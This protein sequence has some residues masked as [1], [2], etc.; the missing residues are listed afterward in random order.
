MVEV[1]GTPFQTDNLTAAQ[2]VKS[3]QKNYQFNLMPLDD[4]KQIQDFRIQVV[5][6]LEGFRLGN[7]NP[8]SRIAWNQIFVNR[9]IQRPMNQSVVM[10]NGGRLDPFQFFLIK[11]ENILFG[12]VT[13]GDRM[14]SEIR[15]DGVVKLL[16]V[17][18]IGREFNGLAV[19]H[20]SGSR[21]VLVLKP[22]VQ[23]IHKGNLCG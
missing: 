20:P 18:R 1:K 9:I 12:K 11:S 6:T 5:V 8:V 14:L 3:S 10:F 13:K 19:H 17:S 23:E 2:A 4:F 16:F 15:G 21:L 7:D 22:L